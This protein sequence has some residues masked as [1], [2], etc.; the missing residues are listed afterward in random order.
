MTPCDC[1]KLKSNYGQYTFRT[2]KQATRASLILCFIGLTS[3]ALVLSVVLAQVQGSEA[4]SSQTPRILGVLDFDKTST[5]SSARYI[6]PSFSNFF[7]AGDIVTLQGQLM[8]VGNWF[9][10]LNAT[11]NVKIQGPDG[12]II[13]EK[14]NIGTNLK[15][16][17][18]ISLPITADFDVGEYV[19]SV[20]PVKAGYEIVDNQYLA[21]FYLFRNNSHTVTDAKSQQTYSIFV[22]SVQFES[23]NVEFNE[24]TRELS[25]DIRRVAGNFA[26]DG[27]LDYPGHFLFLIIERPLIEGTL[28]YRI[29]D[30][31]LVH[32]P[33][34][35][36]NDTSH[37]SQIW[38][39]EIGD[40]AKL[41]FWGS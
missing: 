38:L 41:T 36:D 7:S 26:A 16:G 18:E 20:E 35:Q 25:F 11:A 32:W 22:G 29:D 6:A 15:N 13:Y 34:T 10:P 40:E 2:L 12:T 5:T 33:S 31:Q 4:I 24:K 9:G 39:D 14:R 37:V 8:Q 19:A 27:D 23:S 1:I 28:Q 3:Q 21:P 30:D 17:F